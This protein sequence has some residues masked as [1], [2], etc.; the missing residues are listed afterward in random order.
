MK[1]IALL[2]SIV[3]QLCLGGLYAWSAFEKTLQQ[4]YALEAAQTQLI[5]GLLVTTFTVSMIFAGRLMERRSAVLAAAV[6]G[7]L[8]GGG[9]ILASFSGGSFP[10]LLLT[11]SG[12]VGA[13]TGFAYVCPIA[14]CMKWFPT[15]KGLITGIAVAGFGA[16][17]IVLSNAAKAMFDAN[18]DVLTIFRYV[19]IVYG[20]IVLLSAMAMVSPGHMIDAPKRVPH[21]LKSLM[22]DSFYW[23]LTIAIFCGTFAGL[24]IIGSLKSIG[25]SMGIDENSAILA[26]SIYA[27]GNAAGRISWG[28]LADKLK[29][30]AVWMLL[31][32]IMLAMI[33]MGLL[34]QV[35]PHTIG[36][37]TA[38]A[39]VG[40][41]F[42]GCFIVFAAQVANRYGP[43]HVGSV[44]PM[45]FLAYGISGVFG[46]WTGGKLS[47][48]TGSYTPGILVSIGV[49]TAGLIVSTLLLRR[50]RYAALPEHAE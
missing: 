34:N 31:I 49:L 48:M 32:L 15:H 3:I 19:G 16:G 33:F 5:F 25:I 14:I 11:I 26:I 7:V 37:M 36:F 40:F 50:T 41:G 6:G 18:M 4:N 13:G 1:W 21:S 2:A 27:I 23:A 20:A 42:G 35:P 39:L 47:D 30:R 46:P 10:L 9:Y 29:S 38:A 8:F 24:L 17:A 12:L 22:G 28:F 44:Y 43:D 45:V